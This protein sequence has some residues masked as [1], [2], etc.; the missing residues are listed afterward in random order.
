MRVLPAPAV[1]Q[2]GL[3]LS[4][5]SLAVPPAFVDSTMPRNYKLI[6]TSLINK[7]FDCVRLIQ[8]QL[9]IKQYF[10]ELYL[11]QDSS[12]PLGSDQLDHQWE[13]WALC[14]RLDLPLEQPK[15]WLAGLQIENFI[16]T[17]TKN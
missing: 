13:R 10:S 11:D 17:I 6:S 2:E 3:G 8:D 9:Y 14:Q 15:S 4:N 16:R 1:L 5:G 7:F 12:S